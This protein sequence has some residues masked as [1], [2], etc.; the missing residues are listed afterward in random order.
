MHFT[1]AEQNAV[2]TSKRYLLAQNS[3][4]YTPQLSGSISLLDLQL[5]GSPIGM[6]FTLPHDY[7][8]AGPRIQVQCA[9]GR[10]TQGVDNLST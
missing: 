9:A 4:L 7:P 2:D 5:E 6:H 3:Q 8:V 10:Y 1:A